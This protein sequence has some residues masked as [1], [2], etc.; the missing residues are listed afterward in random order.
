VRGDSRDNTAGT[1]VSSCWP[2]VVLGWICSRS[3][4]SLQLCMQPI[5]I[6][7]HHSLC[8]GLYDSDLQFDIHWIS[9]MTAVQVTGQRAVLAKPT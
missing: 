8:E 4:V 9:A 1:V 2:V 3:E 5:M 6:T 7:R